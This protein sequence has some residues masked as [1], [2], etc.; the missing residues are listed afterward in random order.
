MVDRDWLSLGAGGLDEKAIEAFWNS[1]PCGTSL[2]DARSDEYDLFFRRYDEFRYSTERHILR[3]LDEADF[4]GQRVLEI[5]LG[6]TI[7]RR[8]P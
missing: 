1:H 8:L 5:G 7:F 3:C 6:Q 2:I 4:D